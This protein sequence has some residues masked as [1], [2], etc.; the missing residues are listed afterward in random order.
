VLPGIPLGEFLFERLQEYGVV[1]SVLELRFGWVPAVVAGGAGLLTA[2]VSGFGSARRASTARPVEV[3]TDSSLQRKWFGWFRLLCA[4]LAFGGGL[5]LFIVTMSFTGGNAASTAGPM[6]MLWAVFL[7]LLGPGVAKVLILLLGPLLRV[8]TGL[9]GYLAVSSARTRAIRLAS[10]ITPI[11][12]A[13]GMACTML[14]IQSTQAESQRQGFLENL[15]ADAVLTSPA[16][17]FSPGDERAVLA[18][19]GVL[20]ATP[21]V[22]SSVFYDS[23]GSTGDIAH[24]VPAQGVTPEGLDRTMNIALAAG[25]IADL[26]G[27]TAILPEAQ[28]KEIGV[29]VGDSVALRLGDRSQAR[30]RVVGLSG[31][32]EMI[33]LPVR[34]LAPHT[35]L[36]LAPNMLVRLAPGVSPSVLSGL[37]GV[38]VADR[39]VVYAAQ[40]DRQRVGDWVNYLLAGVIVAY[41]ALAVVNT[42]IMA[43]AER[44]GE[45]AL[46]RLTGATKGQVM[47]MMTVEGV[48]V[49]V[50]GLVLGTVIT[51]STLVPFSIALTGSVW[52]TGSPVVFVVAAAGAFVLALSATLLPSWAALRHRPVEVVANLA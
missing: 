27:N 10:A 21:V 18:V 19:P 14:Y 15:R 4:L 12:L 28:A 8:A 50:C 38:M 46:L 13:T 33:L 22:T 48:L 41:T 17:G 3:L 49:A 43:T 26:R 11:M 52:P 40:A 5:A 29:Q 36:G 1:P 31:N 42:L 7:A 32:S 39:D 44:R 6:M 51:A 45:F 2:I 35:T 16:G 25:N 9:S 47:R 20:A 30:V 24:G 34:L 37:P 23:P